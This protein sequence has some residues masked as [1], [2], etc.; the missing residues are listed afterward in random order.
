MAKKDGQ[1]IAGM[2]KGVIEI[3]AS[4]KEFEQATDNAAM[5]PALQEQLRSKWKQRIEI[6]DL[7]ISRV[8]P[9]GDR[10]YAIQYILKT[11]IHDGNI[12]NLALYG[13]L[14]GPEE[15][16]PPR[17]VDGDRTMFFEKMRLLV[18]VFP[19][20]PGLKSIPE[21][22]D[23]QK[24]KV[25]LRNSLGESLG[26]IESLN[27]KSISILGYRLE[28]RCILKYELEIGRAGQTEIT[29]LVAKIVRPGKA[30]EIASLMKALA[31]SGFDGSIDRIGVPRIY[32]FDNSDGYII[33]EYIRGESLHDLVGRKSFSGACAHAGRLLRKLHA[34]SLPRMKVYSAGMEIENLRGKFLPAVSPFEDWSVELSKAFALLESQLGFAETGHDSTP[35]H[36]DFFDKQM[37]TDGDRIVMLDCDSV[38]LGDPA[39]DFANLLAHLR[40]REM[41]S[42]DGISLEGGMKAFA[43]GYNG[44]N[45]EFLRR[46]EWWLGASLI[47]LS[48]LYALRN[49]WRH[50]APCLLDEAVTALRGNCDILRRIR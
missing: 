46:T 22:L 48:V 31:G 3:G 26:K 33:M 45:T 30:G 28:R 27:I 39:Q 14:F 43:E 10:G 24:A 40:L 4:F 20:D 23:K 7:L 8:F 2:P 49:K 29:S 1:D 50:I 35:I 6:V 44:L 9:R 17:V 37:I 16:W 42:S 12:E 38:A 34:M 11:R 25:I 36:R 41:Q 15:S 19:Y 13:R 5:L 32:H 18:P 47:R 21:L